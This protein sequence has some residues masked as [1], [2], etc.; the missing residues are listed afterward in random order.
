[1]ADV[2][3]PRGTA[4]ERFEAE[5]DEVAREAR[6]RVEAVDRD[7]DRRPREDA[8]VLLFAAEFELLNLLDEDLLDEDLLDEDLLDKEAERPRVEAALAPVERLREDDWLRERGLLARFALVL[9]PATRALRFDAPRLRE[10]AERD[11]EL[12]LRASDAA[13][14]RL[15][16]VEPAEV[17]DAV[18]WLR[19]GWRRLARLSPCSR[20]SAV[21]RPISLLKL[22]RSPCAVSSCTSSASLPASNFWNQ[23]PQSTGSR[24]SA[25]L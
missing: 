2:V 8:V 15:F 10:A 4:C 18:R 24:D 20:A 1:M 7:L 6:P 5:R 17:R 11:R 13:A 12:L 22:L 14:L 3:R 21:S 25:P 9:E 19:S 16:D 23:V